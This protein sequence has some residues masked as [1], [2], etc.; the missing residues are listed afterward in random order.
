ME[1][2]GQVTPPATSR[3]SSAASCRLRPAR[4][5]CRGAS[6]ALGPRSSGKV[7]STSKRLPDRR[8]S[9]GGPNMRGTRNRIGHVS[10]LLSSS[11]PLPHRCVRPIPG[12]CAGRHYWHPDFSPPVG[13]RPRNSLS[14]ERFEG[15]AKD[16]GDVLECPDKH[17]RQPH[18]HLLSRTIYG[19][20]AFVRRSSQLSGQPA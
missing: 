12:G 10:V 15:N 3:A 18:S 6:S 2:V 17:P 1:G 8:S 11:P 4:W 13:L 20:F 5:T 7:P 16:G 14:E 19:I 9:R